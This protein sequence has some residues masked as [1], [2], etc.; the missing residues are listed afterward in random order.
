MDLRDWGWDSFFADSFSA[1]KETGLE[2]AR[3]IEDHG[4]LRKV[5][6]ASGEFLADTAGRLRQ[7]GKESAPVVGDWVAVAVRPGEARGTIKAVLTRRTKLSRRA[8][9]DRGGEQV[10]AANVDAVFA[11]T[12]MNQD[13]NPRRLER[14]LAMIAASGARP[15]V[16]L[17]KED[18]PEDPGPFLEQARA[19]APGVP[20][21][22]SCAKREG[23]AD[24]LLAELKGG[25][26]GVLVGS[27]GVGKSSL[28]NRLLGREKQVTREARPDDDRG[29]HATTFRQLFRLPGGALLID[30]PGVRE[31]QLWAAEKGLDDAFAE[32]AALAENCRFRDCAHAQ[33]PGCAVKKAAE[34]GSLPAERLDSFRKLKAEAAFQKRKEKKK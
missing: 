22:A 1:L 10:A 12:S 21:I 26:T 23:G 31:L 6:A 30:T 8:P 25:E 34:E 13:F 14:Y 4:G 18:L 16:V 7:D 20:V 28:I 11:V 33:E 9:D 27:S 29:R 5:I 32:I 17:N 24:A 3:V 19:A 2:P 15:V